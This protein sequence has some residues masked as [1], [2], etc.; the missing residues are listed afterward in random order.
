MSA[1]RIGVARSLRMAMLVAAAVTTFIETAGA[2]EFPSRPITVL[3]P[4]APGGSSDIV[5][6]LIAQ[7]ASES[8]RQ[9]VVIENRPGAAGNVA[10]LAVKNA[11]PDGYLLLMGHTGTHAVNPS[12]YRDLKF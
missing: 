1:I 7:K 5:M 4:F 2:D 8:F 11:A 10:A 12:L 9:P 3:V 6:R